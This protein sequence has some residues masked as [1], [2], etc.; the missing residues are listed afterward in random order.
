MEFAPLRA[1]CAEARAYEIRKAAQ[2]AMA[3]ARAESHRNGA[4]STEPAVVA[5]TGGIVYLKVRARP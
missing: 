4:F 1:L 3:P 5:D 2:R